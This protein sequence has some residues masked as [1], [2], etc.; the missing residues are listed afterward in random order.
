MMDER[1]NEAFDPRAV[2]E[3]YE[4]ARAFNEAIDLYETV[5]KNEDFYIGNQ[6]RGVHAPDLD[7]PVM[8]VLARVVKFFIASVVSDDIAVGVTDFEEDESRR[9]ITKMIEGKFD[10]IM[11]ATAFKKKTREVIR[12]AAVDGDGCLHYFFNTEASGAQQDGGG[13]IEAEIVEN[14]DIQQSAD[15]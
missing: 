6:W 13:M 5:E 8:N 4:R 9:C 15:A 10:E 1:E 3:E 11:E 12:N 7:K 14:T 2:F